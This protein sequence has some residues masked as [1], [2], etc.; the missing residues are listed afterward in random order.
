MDAPQAHAQHNSPKILTGTLK[1]MHLR[2]LFLKLPTVT[3]TVQ[4]QRGVIQQYEF[5]PQFK[6]PLLAQL[7]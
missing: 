7:D 6:R 2:F 1:R 3:I 5:L 4:A